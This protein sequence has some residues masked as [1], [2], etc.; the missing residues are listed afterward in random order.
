LLK[1]EARTMPPYPLT[2]NKK[3]LRCYLTKF[4]FIR[5]LCSRI[6]KLL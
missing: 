3:Q 6:G 1:K 5:Q 4:Q 2:F